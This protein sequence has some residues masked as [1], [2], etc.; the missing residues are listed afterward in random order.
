MRS[1]PNPPVRC[2][3]AKEHISF[4][5]N[6]AAL[7]DKQFLLK[8]DNDIDCLCEVTEVRFLKQNWEYLV[9]FEGCFDCIN[10]SG[11]EMEEMLKRNSLVKCK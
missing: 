10:M 4:K 11:Q 5:E 1:K 6:P 2:I 3:L 8:E 9:L 7:V